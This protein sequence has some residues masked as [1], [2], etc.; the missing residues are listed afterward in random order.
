[1]LRI[2]SL[3]VITSVIPLSHWGCAHNNSV[4]ENYSTPMS[5]VVIDGVP[6]VK[7][8]DK[9]CGPAAMASVLEYYGDN[10]S[11]DEIAEKVYT[12]KLDGALISD[13]ENFARDQGYRAETMN[14]D[15]AAIEAEIDKGVPVILLVEKGKLM[16]S[17]PHYYVVYGYD[18]DKEVFILHTGDK[19]GQ[20]IKFDKLD[21]EW[22]KMNRLMLIVRK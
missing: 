5:G 15:I 9:F 19:S 4:K 1:M 12:P 13:M 7:Q 8:N 3:I 2:L 6:F 10:V 11:Q 21:S 14:G 16:V 18:K 22:E 17:V 20:E